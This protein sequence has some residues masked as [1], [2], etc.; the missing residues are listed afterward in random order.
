MRH[1]LS[2]LVLRRSIVTRS[3]D[4]TKRRVL[5]NG[6]VEIEAVKIEL[7][8]FWEVGIYL[9]KNRGVLGVAFSLTRAY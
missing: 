6:L 2:F 3:Y 5:T 9:D 4:V 1:E 7:K 8:T